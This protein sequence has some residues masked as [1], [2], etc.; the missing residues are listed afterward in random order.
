[1]NELQNFVLIV[2]DNIELLVHYYRH[3]QDA[4]SQTEQIGRLFNFD[5]ALTKCKQIPNEMDLA[6]M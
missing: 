6:V 3:L 1:M 5:G 4:G 2:L